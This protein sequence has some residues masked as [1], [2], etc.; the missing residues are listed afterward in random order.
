M[1]SFMQAKPYTLEHRG[2]MH[3]SAIQFVS[4]WF[5]NCCPELCFS[6]KMVD[7]QHIPH[8]THMGAAIEHGRLG[9]SQRWNLEL[10]PFDSNWSS[11]GDSL[12]ESSQEREKFGS[13]EESS[14]VCIRKIAELLK[15]E[16]CWSKGR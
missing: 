7:W 2:D 3:G 12:S 11:Q 6:V 1:N 8:D 16:A 5:G 9:E 10:W 15:G 13:C 14:R 4:C